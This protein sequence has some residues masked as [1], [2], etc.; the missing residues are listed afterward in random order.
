MSIP[1]L[2][3]IYPT[4]PSVEMELDKFDEIK[5]ERTEC[6]SILLSTPASQL[7]TDLVGHGKQ[8]LVVLSYC[9]FIIAR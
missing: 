6:T 9:D 5:E 1:E 3:R 2:S 7:D 8:H 4:P